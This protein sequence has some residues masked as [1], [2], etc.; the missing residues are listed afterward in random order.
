MTEYGLFRLPEPAPDVRHLDS[1][2]P[3]PR[4]VT[5]INGCWLKEG[6]ERQPGVEEPRSRVKR[7]WS[8][9]FASRCEGFGGQSRAWNLFPFL[10]VAHRIKLRWLR[11][12]A[13]ACRT[14]G[15]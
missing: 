6:R 10:L 14:T 5:L 2:P 7:D 1:V 9:A 12:E 11:R 4:M 3:W 15:S 8:V 13:A